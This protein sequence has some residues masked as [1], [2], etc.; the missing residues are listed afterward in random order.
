[1]KNTQLKN[2]ATISSSSNDSNITFQ[3]A[4]RDSQRKFSIKQLRYFYT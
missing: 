1:M 2:E 4:F 3:V